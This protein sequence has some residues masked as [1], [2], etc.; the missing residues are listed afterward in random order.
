VNEVSHA[1]HARCAELSQE[2]WPLMAQFWAQIGSPLRPTKE[3]LA[4]YQRCAEEWIKVHGPPRILLLGVTPEIYALRWPKG[5]DFVA[6]DQ[7][8]TMI[9]Y[10]WPGRRNQIVEADWLDLPLPSASRDLVFCDG[11]LHLLEYPSAQLLLV[12]RLHDVIASGGRCIFRLFAAPVVGENDDTVLNDLSAGRIPNLNVLKLRLGM[13]LQE[14]PK[15][16]IE[17]DAIWNSLRGQAGDWDQLAA[18]LGWPV[19]HLRPIDAY[20]NSES[21]YH[22]IS[23]DQAI[24]LF[25]GDGK[26]T[27]VGLHRSGYILGERCPI[28]VFERR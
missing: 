16:G 27:P 1:N 24:E 20:K 3:D 23:E 18:N 28:V 6:V 13:A 11:G 22:F 9:D 17:V 14:S 12:E 8:R 4:H 10:V 26:F 7:T 21:R 15:T 25:C 2:H 5:H 19:E